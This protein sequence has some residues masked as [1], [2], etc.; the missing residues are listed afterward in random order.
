MRRRRAVEA[1]AT[2][3]RPRRTTANCSPRALALIH[4]YQQLARPSAATSPLLTSRRRLHALAST[5][6]DER[7]RRWLR[8]HD[9]E[10]QEGGKTC[11]WI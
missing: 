6:P 11:A 10:D 3:L 4:R 9:A 2:L 7:E 5:P 8:E 1:V